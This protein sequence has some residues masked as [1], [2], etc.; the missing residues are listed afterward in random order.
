[1]K[2]SLPKVIHFLAR[3]SIIH[4]STTGSLSHLL[5]LEYCV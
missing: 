1:M 3:R 2:Y 5:L 4:I